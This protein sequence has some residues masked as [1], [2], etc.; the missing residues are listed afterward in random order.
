VPGSPVSPDRRTPRN[1][2]SMFVSVGPLTGSADANLNLTSLNVQGHI[3]V[4]ICAA[5]SWGN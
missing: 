2:P 5:L 3:Q 4:N 1:L